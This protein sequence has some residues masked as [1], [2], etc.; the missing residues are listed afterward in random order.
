[1]AQVGANIIQVFL[2][3]DSDSMKPHWNKVKDTFNALA[4]LVKRADLDGID[5][6]FTNSGYEA[7]SKDRKGLMKVFNTV[8]PEG[9]CIMKLALGKIL[10]SYRPE[11]MMVQTRGLFSRKKK[12]KWGLSVYVLTDGVWNDGV[13]EL[14][15]VHEPIATL[16]KRLSKNGMMEHH[17][18]IQ[19]IRF[20]DDVTGKRRLNS[21]DNGLRRFKIKK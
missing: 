5:L 20:G 15:G 4:Y 13:D 17:V 1:V 11:P 18:G 16:V 2:V 10:E 12:L 6:Y 19:F 21:L 7:H 3:D 8:K 9:K 14:C